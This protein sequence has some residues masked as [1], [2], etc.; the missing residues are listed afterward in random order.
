MSSPTFAD[1][2]ERIESMQSQREHL[3]KKVE[4]EQ[5]EVRRALSH[6]RH[7]RRAQRII[8]KVA[9]ELQNSTHQ[10]I[11]LVATRCLEIVFGKRYQLDILF[12]QKRGKTEARLSFRREDGLLLHPLKES[13]GGV[14][15]VASFALRLASVIL[16]RPR[17]SR[18]IVLDEPMKNVRGDIY[19]T[20]VREMLEQIAEEMDLQFIINTDLELMRAGKVIKV[21]E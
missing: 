15:D 18:T 1:L 4:D 13:S 10:Q 20:R 3:R 8:Q 19:Q 12:E 17:G 7:A 16:S 5:R 2:A 9:E 21:G 14:A 6:L 11:S